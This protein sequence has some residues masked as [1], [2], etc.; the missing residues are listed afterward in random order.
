MAIST[1]STAPKGDQVVQAKAA[2]VRVDATPAQGTG[3]G[4]VVVKARAA[5]LEIKK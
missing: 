5:R 1:Q 4:T 3:S 2:E